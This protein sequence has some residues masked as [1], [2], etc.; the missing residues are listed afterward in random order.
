MKKNFLLEQIENKVS[1]NPNFDN[2]KEEID[3]IKYQK[4]ENKK[5][6]KLIPIFASLILVVLLSTTGIL[7]FKEGFIPKDDIQ[8]I[9]IDTKESDVSPS[10]FFDINIK[11]PQN[12]YEYGKTINIKVKMTN[13]TWTYGIG[14]FIEKG[15][16]HVKLET[17]GY[18]EII[19]KDEYIFQ[20]VTD[21]DKENRMGDLLM[22]FNIKPIVE[23]AMPEDI[24]LKIKFNMAKEAKDYFLKENPGGGYFSIDFSKEYFL[25]EDIISYM[26]DKNKVRLF[27][28]SNAIKVFEE[29]VNKQ[30]EEGYLTKEECV[31]KHYQYWTQGY[32]ER[33]HIYLDR[34][35]IRDNLLNEEIGYYSPNFTA[36]LQ[37]F[38]DKQLLKSFNE[39]WD[40]YSD[41]QETYT[42]L[43]Q[44]ILEI[45]Y[46]E[47]IITIEQYIKELELI[48]EVDIY[49]I[50]MFTHPNFED[51]EEYWHVDYELK[52]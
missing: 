52:V 39:I 28:C 22:E 33:C 47:N 9:D 21:T 36:R 32:Y 24:Q 27:K 11:I 42:L 13:A 48:E 12:K 16:L 45:L 34:N 2:I 26:T 15:D 18:F 6:L 31:N 40:E 46:D 51:W 3:I 35:D 14:A 29:I 38:E 19:G 1:F 10:K 30:Y 5:S 37:I 17:N 41:D 43:S 50:H 4:N 7:I 8:P 23:N 44:K 25:T 49:I 20:D